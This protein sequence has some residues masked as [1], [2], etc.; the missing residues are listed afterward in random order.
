MRNPPWLAASILACRL[1]NLLEEV[2][3]VAQADW[4]HVDVMDGHFVPNLSMGPQVLQGLRSVTKQFIDCHLMVEN[5]ERWIGPFA[6]AGAHL[7]TVHAEASVH[8]HRIIE[9]I[10]ALDCQAGIALNPG[11]SLQLIEELLPDVDLILLM[12][13]NPGWSGQAF[14]PNVL[15]KAKRLKELRKHHRFLIQ[16]DGG[17]HENNIQA[18]H[19]A[20]VDVFVC[21]SSLFGAQDRAEAIR[22]FQKKLSLKE[23]M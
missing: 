15:Q 23:P 6:E 19:E 20:G 1:E 7:I 21:G 5:P 17:I 11:S 12:S 10:H 13:V 22:I 8:L 16:M 14:I 4:I 3:S 18:I 2:R 9:Q